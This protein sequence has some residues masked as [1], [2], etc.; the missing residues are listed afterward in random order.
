MKKLLIALIVLSMLISAVPV[1]ANAAV[2]QNIVPVF[3]EVSESFDNSIEDIITAKKAKGAIAVFVQDG[4]V[5]LSK[6]YG[7]ADELLNVKAD[8]EQIGFRIG[9]ISKTFVA[10]TALKAMEEGKLDMNTDISAYLGQDAPKLK[11]PVT[12]EHLLTHTAG[13]EEIITGMAVENVSDTEPLSITVKKYAPEQIFKPGEVS[14]YSNYGIALAAFVVE[15]A[16]NVNFAE[17]CMNNIFLP[18]GMNRTTFAYMQDTVY[19]SKAYL[20]NGNETEDLYMNLYPEGSAV[21][22]AEDMGKYIKW[23]M[24]ED[25]VILSKENKEKLFDCQ[26][27]MA[28]ELSGIGYVWNRKER[29]DTI[30]LEKKGETLHF[31]SRIALYPE[32][33]TGYFLSFNTY[34]PE[35]EINE[36][37][38]RVTDLL[39][40]EKKFPVSKPG[41][42]INIS[43]CYVNAWSS[44]NTSEKLLRYFI[45]G[46]MIDISG[47]M[48]GGYT[49]NDE[50]ITHLGNNAYSTPAGTVKFTERDGNVLMATDYSQTYIRI[51]GLENKGV[52]LIITFLF[53]MSSLI[54]SVSCFVLRKR[55][56]TV[57]FGIISLVQVTM[58]FVLGYVIYFGIMR[59][60]L[61]DYQIY[62]RIASWFMVLISALFILLTLVNQKKDGKLLNVIYFHDA[63]TAAFCFMML[64]LR[65]LA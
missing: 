20:P 41:A 3:E 38:S 37:S 5:V 10:V 11:Y 49:F 64:N 42:T 65:F 13:F 50:Q 24:S 33:K 28:D 59:F 15:R 17:Y 31:Y 2:G 62:I 56:G 39:L 26:F 7:Y 60:A 14:S 54:C 16:T 1:F 30:Y 48:K 45:P 46:K 44:F 6:G 21:S 22:T 40:G 52:T 43:G 63:I 36:I 58:F 9:S 8:K 53:L 47:S 29:N 12:M 27:Y 51:N 35:N 34:V 19:V 4:E 32:Q 18:L 23:L 61:L 57:M 55:N 25:E